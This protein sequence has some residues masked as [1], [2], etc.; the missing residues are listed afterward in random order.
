MHRKTREATRERRAKR[1]GIKRLGIDR[2]GAAAVEFAILA[3]IFLALLFSILEAGYYFFVN[4]A[5]DAANTHAARLIR[6]GQAQDGALDRDAFF[7]EICDV[8][9]VFGNCEERLTVDVS[10][11]SSFSALASDVSNPVCRDA[12]QSLIDD[13]PFATGGARDIV[14]VRVCFLYRGFNPALGLN[15]Q[16]AANG[17]FQMLSTSIFRNEPF[18]AS[19]S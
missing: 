3:P 1:F 8:V 9:R 16:R 10:R 4:S 18:V 13:L 7:D 15:L 12:D 6:T 11:F 5:V 2:S 17:D 19:G 14:R